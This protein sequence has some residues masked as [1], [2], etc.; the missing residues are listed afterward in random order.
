MLTKGAI[1]NFLDRLTSIE[2]NG[3]VRDITNEDK[4]EIVHMNVFYS[5]RGMRVL[6]F[7]KR[8]FSNKTDINENDENKYR[9]ASNGFSYGCFQ[10]QKNESARIT[11]YLRCKFSKIHA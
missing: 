11:L 3:R 8:E 5:E 2:V 10:H 6:C 7:A 4:K 9:N 1:D